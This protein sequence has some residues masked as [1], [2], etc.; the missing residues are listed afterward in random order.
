M[1][2]DV[3][4]GEDEHIGSMMVGLEGTGDIRWDRW[5]RGHWVASVCDVESG[6]I[7]SGG[8]EYDGSVHKRAWAEPARGLDG[9]VERGKVGFVI[10]RGDEREG[11]G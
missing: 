6:N 2:A 4:A 8:D 10:C 5:D 1:R 9:D 7:E 11:A 3:V